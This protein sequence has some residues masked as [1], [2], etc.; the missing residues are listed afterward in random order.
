MKVLLLLF[1]VVLLANDAKED[2]RIR[3]QFLR[4]TEHARKAKAE[5]VKLAEAWEKLCRGRGLVIG[6]DEFGLPAPCVA[7]KPPEPNPEAKK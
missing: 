7:P 1:P 4:Y 5:S 2:T 6:R 3:K